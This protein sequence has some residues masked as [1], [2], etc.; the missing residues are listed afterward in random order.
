ME[1]I[2]EA[3]PLPPA[4][5]SNKRKS[6]SFLLEN[7]EQDL[8]APGQAHTGKKLPPINNNPTS[9]P[10]ETVSNPK[11]KKAI[12]P[13]EFVL[14]AKDGRARTPKTK[15]EQSDVGESDLI[16]TNN[17]RSLLEASSTA[18]ERVKRLMRRASK[19][20]VV[21]HVLDGVAMLAKA[22]VIHPADVYV[23]N[24][25]NSQLRF[26]VPED[27]SLFENVHTFHGGENLLPFAKLGALPSLRRLSLPFNEISD[28]DLEVDGLFPLLE[29]LDLSYNHTSPAAV[30][31]LA[32]LPSLKSLDLTSN[33]ITSLPIQLITSMPQ[34]REKPRNGLSP[35]LFTLQPPA[36]PPTGFSRSK[37][38][39]PS[40]P[41]VHDAFKPILEATA[42]EEFEVPTAPPPTTPGPPPPQPP[43]TANPDLIKVPAA[44]ALP[45]PV[46]KNTNDAIQDD[47][48][49][50][51]NMA[52]SEDAVRVHT[53]KNN[54]IK[55]EVLVEPTIAALID[56]G[57]LPLEPP[58]TRVASSHA[59]IVQTPAE[60]RELNMMSRPVE[61]LVAFA[62]LESLVLERNGL[63]S[64]DS[65]RILGHLPNLK[66]LNLNY[67]K[68]RTLFFLAMH[69]QTD[70]DESPPLP[71][72]MVKYDGFHKLQ[73]LRIAFNRIDS[74]QGLLALIHL[75]V[76]KYIWIEGNPVLARFGKEQ[77]SHANAVGAGTEVPDQPTNFKHCDPLKLFPRI[78]GIEILDLIYQAPPSVLEDTYY[79]L[80]PV[81]ATGAV[82]L[83]RI[84]RPPP[85]DDDWNP[86]LVTATEPAKPGAL[87]HT[88][89]EAVKVTLEELQT[90]R[91]DIKLTDEEV[92]ETV[93]AG[94][95]LTLKE[96]KRIRKREE[97][98]V[99]KAEE[100]KREEEKRMYEEELE[101]ERKKIEE[102]Q[103]EKLREEEEEAAQN[104][105]VEINVDEGEID[106]V[107]PIML[108]TVVNPDGTE[109]VYDPDA[110]DG[111][112]LT[113]VHITGGAGDSAS[114]PQP[115]SE[116]DDSNQVGEIPTDSSAPFQDP[117]TTNPALPETDSSSQL[118]STSTSLSTST[119]DNPNDPL[120]PPH[121]LRR[122][123]NTTNPKPHQKPPAAARAAEQRREMA[124][125][126][127]FPNT[128]QASLR[129]L[130]HALTNPISY[131]RLMEDSYAK[132]TFAHTVRVRDA[133]AEA[134]EVR[135]M[136]VL[137]G[138]GVYVS[139]AEREEVLR[140]EYQAEMEA[141]VGGVKREEGVGGGG[142]EGGVG[143]AVSSTGRSESSSNADAMV[144]PESGNV[145]PANSMWTTIAIKTQ[146]EREAA[147][148]AAT[149][150]AKN[151]NTTAKIAGDG[152]A[153]KAITSHLQIQVPKLK[154]L[155]LEEDALHL[156]QQLAQE[157][158][159]KQIKSINEE[160]DDDAAGGDK[161]ANSGGGVGDDLVSVNLFGGGVVGVSDGSRSTKETGSD[162]AG[163]G[164]SA[165][166]LR[167]ERER[168][169][170]RER[171]RL[172]QEAAER[173]RV[174]A[175]DED[176][177]EEDYSSP[178]RR[179]TPN[180]AAVL[181]EKRAAEYK[182]RM[183]E[184][185]K[186]SDAKRRFGARKLR[187]KDEFEEMGAM[188][189]AV[190][191]KLEAIETNLA[192]ILNSSIMHKHVPQSRKLITEVQSEY[193][194]IEK[195]YNE[196][197]LAA[198]E[199][200]KMKAK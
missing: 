114:Q 8:P 71:F 116:T 65:L 24:V 70:E 12:R 157:Q 115:Q 145:S 45:P 74:T 170:E 5:P 39:S 7:V 37:P 184:N 18:D 193:K 196:S 194:R 69:Q 169:E 23:L 42:K 100:R 50:V 76:L 163:A 73:E 49:E 165:V 138:G 103:A 26:V 61:G 129:A 96:L 147:I 35:E 48:N 80:A 85:H 91:R 183:L 83:R 68:Y 160:N 99:Q 84:V 53:V 81:R 63:S 10:V 20:L 14:G 173:A 110:E 106:D 6:L 123:H 162:V 107:A 9:K 43:P 82:A 177:E 41:L 136:K 189:S 124:R 56:A 66:K 112:F 95:V 139:P 59:L 111:T 127:Q 32:T 13:H 98:E 31:V 67:N 109:M 2:R 178:Q 46:T 15:H 89:G 137:N 86:V 198:I 158:L 128:I 134:E 58:V 54:E 118:D 130:R 47:D 51:V 79:A 52:F 185:K 105:P 17:A 187:Y 62:V 190:D 164:K 171:E 38:L 22:N 150:A 141:K 64:E 197:A 174:E 87:P 94:R 133:A 72:Q 3:S 125:I 181:A 93:R 40:A 176:D 155:F 191:E 152:K 88:V 142:G 113:G 101:K 149:R 102:L 75:P 156:A 19:N 166:V 77:V 44:E 55:S 153:A 172:V 97:K 119:F 186:V 199:A 182:R 11:A 179:L 60:D 4:A 25:A 148:V 144:G 180:E 192:S 1:P 154:G 16:A 90:R 78:Y 151:V 120:Y 30:I 195:M 143:R 132:P 200:S 34:W 126:H 175:E 167:L 36:G 27:L 33:H 29:Q 168:E 92:K 57:A 28:L 21:P 108:P 188:M 161:D 117:P 146:A 135:R 122:L 159:S 121:V 131:W 104:N 140:R